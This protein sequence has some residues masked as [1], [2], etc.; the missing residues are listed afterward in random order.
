MRNDWS[1]TFIRPL[2]LCGKFVLSL[3]VTKSV[4]YVHMLLHPQL[5]QIVKN[6][7]HKIPANNRD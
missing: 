5:C 7:T 4:T 3:V 1:F 2:R 6:L